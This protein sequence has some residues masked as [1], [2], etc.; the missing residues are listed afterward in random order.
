MNDNDGLAA[1]A[2]KQLPQIDLATIKHMPVGDIIQMKPLI[3]LT[4]LRQAEDDLRRAKMVKDWLQGILSQKYEE[5]AQAMRQQLGR[6]TGTVRIEDDGYAIVS[7]LP[8]KIEW[9]QEKLSQIIEK[10]LSE[11][12][13][14]Q[15]LAK[16]EFK[17]SE[18]QFNELPSGVRGQLEEAR[19]IKVG[20]QTF[21]IEEPKQQ[22]PET[23][24]EQ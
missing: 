7:D 1:A 20:K 9:D 2:G 3:L 8:K 5:E 10:L 4:L 19:T 11:G 14:I 17:V 23:E 22:S 12:W 6:D 15:Q 18:R 13:N 21:K 24:G 16:R